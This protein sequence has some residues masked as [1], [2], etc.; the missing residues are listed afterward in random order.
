MDFPATR[1]DE[2]SPSA[3]IR[4]VL[5]AY[6]TPTSDNLKTGDIPQQWIGRTHEETMLSCSGCPLLWEPGR[7]IPR[8]RP[9]CYALRGTVRMAAR[10]VRLRAARL[11]HSYT[12]S[13]ALRRRAWAARAVRFAAIGCV[14]ATRETL[15]ADIAAVH[16]EGLA[17]LAY[18]HHSREFPELAGLVTASV[19]SVA[20]AEAAFAA[21]FLKVALVVPKSTTQREMRQLGRRL[22]VKALVC[23]ADASQVEHGG[24]TW[25]RTTCNDCRLCDG[26]SGPRTLIG[27]PE[28]TSARARPTLLDIQ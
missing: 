2:S 7:A 15:A 26:T 22:G 16:A 18:C 24:R 27:F 4:P 28:K 21:R 8:D 1:P 19:G 14:C 9:T 13:E 20:Q 3:G 10:G 5:Q 17:T 6:W 11:P 25:Y 12:L 23:P